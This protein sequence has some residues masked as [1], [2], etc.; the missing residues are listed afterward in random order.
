MHIVRFR[1]DRNIRMY[2]I[3][4]NNVIR[5]LDGDIFGRF[6]DTG[7][8]VSAEKVKILSPVPHPNKIIGIGLNYRKHVEEWAEKMGK[9]VKSIIP[10]EPVIFLKPPTTRIGNFGE[11]E[12]PQVSNEVEFEAELAVIIGKECRNIK[13]DEGLKAVFGYTCANDVTARDIQRKDGQWTRAK[14]FD[15]FCPLGPGIVLQKGYDISGWNVDFPMNDIRVISHPNQLHVQG[16]LNNTVCQDFHT[17]DMI[18]SVEEIIAYISGV[19]SLY[20]GDIILTGTGTG[21]QKLKHGDN[22]EIE[23]EKIGLLSN[24]VIQK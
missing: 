5:A 2:G 4:K 1:N 8:D 9:T 23:I 19:M 12:L 10:E 24:R 22:V 17:S 14:G 20:P 18:F 11:I 7:I 13:K 21:S 3:Q 6:S 16:K 15:S